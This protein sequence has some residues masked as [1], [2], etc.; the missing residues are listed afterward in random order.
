MYPMIP[1]SELDQ[2]ALVSDMCAQLDNLNWQQAGSTDD[3]VVNVT[4][5]IDCH[6]DGFRTVTEHNAG[7]T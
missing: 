6:Y 1:T 5:E 7:I 2:H 4:G 3:V